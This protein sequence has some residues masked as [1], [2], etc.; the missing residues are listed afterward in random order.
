VVVAIAGDAGRLA[1][2]AL[3]RVDAERPFVVARHDEVIAILPVYV[4]RGPAELRMALERAVE[5]LGR[6]H[7]VHLRA[8]VSSVGSGLSAIARCYGEALRALRHTSDGSAVVALQDVALLDYLASEADDTARRLAP[9]G[10]H[11]LLEADRQFAGALA[12]TLHAYAGCD[13]NVARAAKR[14][15]V[16]PNTVHYRLRR[17]GDLT[18][19]DPRRFGDLA[20]LLTALRLLSA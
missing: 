7:D 8:G 17:I 11:R 10:A 20:E 12:E 9:A 3:I 19:R 16:H 4:R 15:A 14:L 5:G 13:L 18:G 6:T 1:V 2:R